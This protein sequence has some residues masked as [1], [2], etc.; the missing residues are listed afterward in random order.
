MVASVGQTHFSQPREQ[1]IK[2]RL[3]PVIAQYYASWPLWGK[4]VMEKHKVPGGVHLVN[5]LS[6][7]VRM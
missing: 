5:K 3:Y 7:D 4:V 6:F 2:F 1:N